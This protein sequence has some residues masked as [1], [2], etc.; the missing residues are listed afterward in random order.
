MASGRTA[1]L[2]W[3]NTFTDDLR[4]L[5]LDWKEGNDGQSQS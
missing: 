5:E 2:T 3:R 1:W 4:E